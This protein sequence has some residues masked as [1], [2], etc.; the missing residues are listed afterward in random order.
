MK[1]RA[2]A[3]VAV[4]AL[5]TLVIVAPT[6]ASEDV[7]LVRHM[8]TLQYMTQKAGLAIGAQNQPLASFY[9]H[10]LEEVIEE[11]ETVETYDGHAIGS[12]VKSIL[13]PSFEALEGAVKSGDWR[14]AD[15]RFDQ[16]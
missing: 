2:V 8:G 1:V 9:V 4:C 15:K 11:L 6:H 13:V 5:M 14:N 7:E 10:E 12:L 3:A 16:L